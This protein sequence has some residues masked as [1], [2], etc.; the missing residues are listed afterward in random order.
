MEDVDHGACFI[1]MAPS[2]LNE[3][4]GEFRGFALTQLQARDDDRAGAAIGKQPAVGGDK[5]V[6]DGLVI[7][8]GREGTQRTS[9]RRVKNRAMSGGKHP[10]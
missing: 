8:Q 5:N 2:F 4:A 9:N 1:E 3:A 6:G 7:R 10:L